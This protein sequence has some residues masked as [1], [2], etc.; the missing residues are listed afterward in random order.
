MKQCA[1]LLCFVF[2]FAS[3]AGA[4]I[5]DDDFDLDDIVLDD[6]TDAESPGDDA[7]AE[8]F[9]ESFDELDDLFEDEEGE[10]ASGSYLT[11]FRGFLE[12][13]PRIYFRDRGEE[14]NDEQYIFETELEL[15]FRFHRRLTGYVRPRLLVDLNDGDLRRFEPYEAYI[16]WAGEGWDLR[17]GQFVENWG[18]VDTFNP[19]D[20]INRRDFGSDLLD[21]DRLGELGARGRWF[22]DGGDTIGE[23]SASFYWLPAWRPT[24]FAPEDQRFSFDSEQ[25]EFDEDAGFEPEGFERHFLAFRFQHTLSTGPVNAD[26]QYLFARGP[27]RT[28]DVIA[29]GGN[30][31]IPAYFGV[32]TAGVGFRAVPN[33][34]VAGAFLAALTLKAEVVYKDPYDF[35]NSPI[36]DP[37]D[38]VAA[39]VGCDRSFYNVVVDQDQLTLTVEY[40]WEEGADDTSSQLRPFRNDIIVRALWE[41]NDFART[42]WEVR[43][44]YDFDND[45]KVL[46]TIF[47]RQLRA[48]HEDL[49]LS[50]QLQLFDPPKTGES[51]FDFFPNNSSVAVALR[52]DF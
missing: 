6:S 18:I 11:G 12:L 1:W 15:D 41:M 47:E 46:E 5:D 23:P 42:S 44:F 17:A 50:L 39:V 38:Y 27:E 45:E 3:V 49:K 7:L 13:R 28:P 10:P 2:L 14:S 26:L 29:A 36:S 20:V 30:R 31:L 43:S 24:L 8:D 37:D 4:Q 51:L 35:D 34:D 32:A 25:L 16:T 19:I 40:A 48:I 21:A 33:E 52:L 9:D 22:F